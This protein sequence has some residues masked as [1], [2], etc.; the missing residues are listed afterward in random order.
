[1]ESSHDIFQSVH[2]ACRV[3][4]VDNDPMVLSYIRALLRPTS[5]GAIAA[6]DAKLTDPAA[7]L[8]ACATLDFRPL[9]AVL[10]PSMLMFIPSAARAA[11]MSSLVAA[12][13]PG[14]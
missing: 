9:A 2:P 7:L 4:Y 6:P 10:L 12:L 5:L 3:F 1:M 11:I 13:A 8:G 14:S